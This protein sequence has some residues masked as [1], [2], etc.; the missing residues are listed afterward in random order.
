MENNLTILNQPNNPSSCMSVSG[1][2]NIDIMLVITNLGRYIRT[3]KVDCYCTTSDHNLIITELQG[4]VT[5]NRNW[6][7]DLGF[8]E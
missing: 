3:W 2:S 1:Q 7:A 6:N 8:N 5:I 4:G